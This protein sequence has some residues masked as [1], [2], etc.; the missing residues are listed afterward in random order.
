[1]NSPTVSDAAAQM[2]VDVWKELVGERDEF[3]I[4]LRLLEAAVRYRETHDPRP[5]GASNRRAKA[6]GAVIGGIRYALKS[7]PCCEIIF[8]HHST[9]AHL[10][11]TGGQS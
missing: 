6:A 4:P 2:W 1:M 10:H 3:Q 7:S 11:V 5:V 9:F 8:S